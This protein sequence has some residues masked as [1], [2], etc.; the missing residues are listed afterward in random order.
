MLRPE[1]S[2][3]SERIL[4]KQFGRSAPPHR[5]VILI[6]PLLY[7][8][9]CATASFLRIKKMIPPRRPVYCFP[10]SLITHSHRRKLLALEPVK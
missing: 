6:A 3:Q 5:C 2:N 10:Y 1:W 7:A 4:T 9:V 8:V